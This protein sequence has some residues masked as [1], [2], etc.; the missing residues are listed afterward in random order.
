M[1]PEMSNSLSPPA[2][3]GVYPLLLIPELLSRIRKRSSRQDG[4]P[5]VVF[6]LVFA[7]PDRSG[8]E[9]EIRVC[10]SS[11]LERAL[12]SFSGCRLRGRLTVI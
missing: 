1:L 4:R 11:P 5:F 8:F 10:G 6:R 7:Q 3:P 12:V 2:E 9:I